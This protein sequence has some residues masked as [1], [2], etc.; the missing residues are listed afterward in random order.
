MQLVIDV[1]QVKSDR[2]LAN[3]ERLTD[4]LITFAGAQQGQDL[5]LACAELGFD[6]V[7]GILSGVADEH[8]CDRRANPGSAASN[9][10]Y[11][12]MKHRQ[13]LIFQQI[14]RGTRLQHPQHI[15]ESRVSSDDQN[16]WGFW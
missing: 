2:S 6:R 1:P 5:S 10:T 16:K 8:R 9:R 13:I 3:T 11:R 4:I 15:L 12:I 14:A 7:P